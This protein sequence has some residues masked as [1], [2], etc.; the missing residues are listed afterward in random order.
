MPLWLQRDSPLSH[1]YRLAYAYITRKTNTASPP[2]NTKKKI[3]RC[4]FHQ[5]FVLRDIQ[6]TFHHSVLS[7]LLICNLL[8]C[9]HSIQFMSKKINNLDFVAW[10]L[11][12]DELVWFSEND[13]FLGFLYST[14][15]KA[16]P[17]WCG[18]KKRL[19]AGQ[20]NVFFFPLDRLRKLK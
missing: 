7:I 9:S 14:G 10:L 18:G 3:P 12:P 11:V 15:F 16:Y 4:W 5:F 19:Q 1:L 2:L 6:Y 8:Y 13:D 20:G 17:E